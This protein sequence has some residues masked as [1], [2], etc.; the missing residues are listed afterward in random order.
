MKRALDVL[1]VG[2]VAVMIHSPGPAHA[3]DEDVHRLLADAALR[4]L[5]DD[6]RRGDDRE[7]G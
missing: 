6:V 1:P 4:L 2:V 7:R 5:A 3:T